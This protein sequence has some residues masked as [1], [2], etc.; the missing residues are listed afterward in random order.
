MSSIIKVNT[1]QDVDGNNIINENANTITIGKSGDTVQVASGATLTGAGVDWQSVVTAATLTAV[2]GRGYP[3]NT[4]SNACTITLP[5]SASVGDQIIFTDYA[6]YWYTNSL[7]INPNSL[8]YQGNTTPQPNYNTSG[9][10]VHIV[11]MDV[12]KG[13]IPINDGTVQLETPQSYSA[14]LLVVAG[15][16][17][18][19]GWTG[20]GGG[21]GGYRTSTQT[22]SPPTVYTVTVGDGGAARSG[23]TTPSRG[24]NGSDSSI[25]GSGLTT[26]TSTAGGG[27][28]GNG[29][30]EGGVIGTGQNGGS[31]G[32]GGGYNSKPAGS[33]DTPATVPSQGNDGS[34]SN[35]TSFNLGGG[36]GAGAV[37]GAT[38]TT[39]GGNG[40]AG[41][42]SSITGA[43]VTYAGG[44]GGHSSH[45][46]AGTGG[47]G[48]GGAGSTGT[49]SGV[50][51]TANTGGGGGGMRDTGVSGTGGKGVVIVSVPDGLY[52]GNTTGTPTVQTNAGGTGK[53]VM[54]FTG[55]GTY[56]S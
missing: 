45:T 11:Y 37:G 14:D 47:A 35:G 44:G 21:A 3:I 40:G 10:S 32:G 16:G 25:S 24:N 34:D 30:D 28:G 5:A 31:G 54:T 48:G 56:T 29:T 6:R 26:I 8:N 42:A 55:D 19:G 38:T 15:G 7:T 12:T 1:V 13:W 18:G 4:T 46:A 41:T 53:T 22:F 17:S 23:S 20:G 2:A 39:T 33:G 9:E 49:G 51:G 43:S 36:G 52:S 50:N 27:G